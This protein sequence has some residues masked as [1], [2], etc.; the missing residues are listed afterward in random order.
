MPKPPPPVRHWPLRPLLGVAALGLTLAFTAS[1]TYAAARG[2]L[3]PGEGRR[4]AAAELQG[5]A[6]TFWAVD[7]AD[8]RH[9]SVLGQ[10]ENADGWGVRAQTSPDGRFIAYTVFPQGRVE[11]TTDSEL[12]ALATATGAQRRLATGID[13]MAAPRWLPDSTLV[14]ARRTSIDT[15]DRTDGPSARSF[16]LLGFQPNVTDGLPQPLATV[17]GVDWAG[18]VGWRDGVLAY[19]TIDGSGTWLRT[20]GA[21]DAL[22]LST[23]IARDFSLAPDGN[24]LSFAEAPGPATPV[25]RLATADLTT[26][27]IAPV[28]A[29]DGAFNPVWAPSG[30]LTVGSGANQPALQG[31]AAV[32]AAGGRATSVLRSLPGQ[33]LAPLEWS[34]D[35][36]VL[37]ARLASG[38]ADRP[39]DDH[40]AVVDA[41]AGLARPLSFAGYAAFA[42]WLP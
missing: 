14:V 16:A 29:P 2:P 28:N 42:G 11:P 31:S 8:P 17:P 38:T 7:P 3:A 5:A 4:L 18:A 33:F 26:R 35:G 39:A 22:R 41:A 10:T 20:A 37:A 27:Q 24:R 34:P 15:V 36:A 19:A 9:R 30:A 6:T 13:L 1:D 40:L 32:L 12:W 25:L 23:G 21:D